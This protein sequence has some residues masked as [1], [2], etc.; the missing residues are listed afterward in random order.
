MKH[1]TNLFTIVAAVAVAMFA[2]GC[3][4]TQSTENM[5][6]TAGFK[7][8]TPKNADH[9]KILASLPAGKISVLQYKGKTFY[10]Y[11]DAKNNLAYVGT[12]NEYTAF[13]QLKFAQNIS[14]QNLAAAQM[15][16]ASAYGWWGGPAGWGGSAVGWR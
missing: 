7:A 9:Q 5:L 10:A 12:P 2:T 3:A 14:D 8:M 16:Q 11:P 13:R 1:I 6:A 4:S 15:N